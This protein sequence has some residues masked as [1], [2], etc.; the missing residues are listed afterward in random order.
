MYTHT[1]TF[2]DKK[3]TLTV[4]LRVYVIVPRYLQEEAKCQTVLTSHVDKSSEQRFCPAVVRLCPAVVRLCP[5]VV[6]LCPA[7]VIYT[8]S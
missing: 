8:N 7:M 4:T 2:I 6:R 5:A 3:V 1:H